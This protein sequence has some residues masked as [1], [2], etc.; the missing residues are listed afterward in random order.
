MWSW[1]SRLGRTPEETPDERLARLIIGTATVLG[2]LLA[3]VF[4]SLGDEAGGWS[5]QPPVIFESLL[6]VLLLVNVGAFVWHRRLRLFMR[7]DGVLTILGPF[8]M[9][10][11]NDGM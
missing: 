9:V 10:L 2:G 8:G 11:L 7:L 1:L 6:G 5:P 3:L 4:A